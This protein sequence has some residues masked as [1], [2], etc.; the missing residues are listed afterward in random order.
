MRHAGGE[1]AGT[2]AEPQGVVDVAIRIRG[3]GAAAL[4][5]GLRHARPRIAPLAM[6]LTLSA[7]KVGVAYQVGLQLERQE[8]TESTH[9]NPKYVR[10]NG[11][12]FSLR[13][14]VASSGASFIYNMRWLRV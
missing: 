6:S 1:A 2:S 7:A 11:F 13:R 4:L 8:S 9:T 12:M 10:A 5:L 14:A 3:Y